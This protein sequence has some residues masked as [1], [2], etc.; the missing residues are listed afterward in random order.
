MIR[1]DNIVI[2]NKSLDVCTYASLAAKEC[3]ATI[4]NNGTCI[5]KDVGFKCDCHNGYTGDTCTFGSICYTLQI[6][7]EH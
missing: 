1:H 7:F 2:T 3:N 5:E 4:C 6:L